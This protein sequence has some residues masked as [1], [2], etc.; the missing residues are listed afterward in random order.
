[1]MSRG[2]LW[3]RLGPLGGVWWSELWWGFM[4]VCLGVYGILIGFLGMS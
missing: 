2:V 3:F 1:M 4:G